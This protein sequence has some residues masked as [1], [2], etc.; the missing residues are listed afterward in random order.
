MCPRGADLCCTTWAGCPRSLGDVTPTRMMSQQRQ[1]PP[2]GAITLCHTRGCDVTTATTRP[3]VMSHICTMPCMTSHWTRL[4]WVTPGRPPA[5]S[6]LSPPL[7][8]SAMSPRRQGQRSR[9]QG[10]LLGP[11][12]GEG[13]GCM[14]GWY[15][16]KR[17]LLGGGGGSAGGV[18]EDLQARRE[19]SG[20]WCA[21]GCLRPAPSCYS[22]HL[23]HACLHPAPAPH[24]LY[25]APSS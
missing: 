3:A 14:L 10:P 13:G 17:G 15:G 16:E 11:G 20:Q 25:L 19:Q 7:S 12:G 5:V 1:L 6:Q 23:F 22:L 4:R 8:G 21:R 24:I 18:Q 9:W 2:T